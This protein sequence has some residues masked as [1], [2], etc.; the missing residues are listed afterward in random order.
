VFHF[1]PE[2]VSK[3]KKEDPRISKKF[4]GEDA[5]QSTYTMSTV[6]ST[7]G[8]TKK[9]KHKP[10]YSDYLKKFGVEYADAQLKYSLFRAQMKAKGVGDFRQLVSEELEY[11]YFMKTYYEDVPALRDQIHPCSN[12]PAAWVR[13]FKSF[14][15]P[16]TFESDLATLLIFS[17]R[18][19]GDMERNNWESVLESLPLGS[20]SRFVLALFFIKSTNGVSDKVSCPHFKELAVTISHLLTLQIYLEPLVIAAILRQTSKWVKNTVRVD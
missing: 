19:C 11:Y 20:V 7:H 13:R 2:D 17:K 5:T 15:P 12:P 16:T 9:K 4:E 6:S 1:S 10:T 8:G 14:Q 3:M 18:N